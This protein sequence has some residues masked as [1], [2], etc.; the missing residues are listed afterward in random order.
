MKNNIDLLIIGAGPFGLAMASY[1]Q[2]LGINYQL[3]GIPM[4]FW[5]EHMPEGMYLRSGID[6]HIDPLNID[7]IEKYIKSLNL[8]STNVEPISRQFY[9]QYVQWFQEQKHIK[10]I[11]KLV[12]QLDWLPELD[13]C[14]QAIL[15]DGEVMSAKNVVIAV[16]FEYFKNLPIKLVECLPT[17]SFTHTCDFVDFKLLKGKTCLIIGGRQSAFEWAALLNE[18]G[19]KSVHIAYRHDT[20]KFERADWSWVNPLVDHLIDDPSWY[21]NL[22]QEEK[23]SISLRLWSEGRLKI[24]PW[25]EAKVMKEAVKLWPNSQIIACQRQTEE[26]FMV[27]LDTGEILSVQHIILATGYKVNIAGV[28]FLSNGNM[29]NKMAIH[30]DF[31]L[32]DAQFQTNI[33]GLF[34]TSMA[35][36]QDFGPFFA[37][38]IAVRTSAKVIGQA[39][40]NK[41]ISAEIS[42]P[43]KTIFQHPPSL[44]IA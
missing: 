33:P 15:E 39:I 43:N 26:E 41:Q 6:W 29:I 20:P 30:H 27:S 17:N 5:K 24:E 36:M 38:T 42:T 16:G 28:P 31:P 7:T 21:R 34:I 10:P 2:Y 13:H 12:Q 32:L 14:F 18:A 9:L 1:A 22:T 25:L 37:F 40:I 23:N 4:H 44:G 35:A 3:V 19:A 11:P 8:S